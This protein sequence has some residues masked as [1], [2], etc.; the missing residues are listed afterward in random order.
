MKGVVIAGVG[1][2][3][4]K[5]SI[6]TGLMALFSEEMH[7]QG[8]K[9]G[10]DFI[11]P[12]YHTMATGR[13]SR[14]IDTFMM[15]AGTAKSL[16]A[17]SSKGADLCIVEGVRGL[18]E[19][20]SGTSEEC[21]TAEMAKILGF[22]VVLVIDA[23]SLTRS[24]AAIINGFK[25]FDPDVNISGVILN[26]VSGRHHEQKLREAIE[27]RCD[28]EIVGFVPSNKADKVPQRHLGLKTPSD[29]DYVNSMKDLV[30]SLDKDRLMDMTESSDADLGS[31][32]LYFRRNISA[33]VAVPYDEAFCFYYSENIECLEAS[34]FRVEKFSPLK[35]DALPESDMYYLGGGYPELYAGQLS[36][37]GDFME[38]LNAAAEEG[39]PIMGECGGLMT[40]CSSIFWNGERYLMSGIF[41]GEATESCRHGPKY[42]N[43]VSTGKNPLFKGKVRGHEFH[44]SEIKGYREDFGFR[45]DRGLGINSGNDGLV[46]GNCLGTY[47][48]QHALSSEDWA[49]GLTEAIR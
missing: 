32:D 5:T 23:K 26:N 46:K 28:V 7:V 9:I 3:V 24:A 29:M 43:A 21:S 41:S 25:S 22:P 15:D 42:T 8:Y 4:G 16:V 19:G 33:K 31:S 49:Q 45:L 14:N 34:G 12:M 18:Y 10:P 35:G 36:E 37:N 27:S 38:G 47:M 1:S 20:L 17:H 6:S 11:D 48:H 39:K 44:Y 40:M 13:Q 2:G 30:S